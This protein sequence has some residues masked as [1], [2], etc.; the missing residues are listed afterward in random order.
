MKYLLGI[1]LAAASFSSSATV[2]SI[3]SQCERDYPKF[4]EMVNCLSTNIMRDNNL[5]DDQEAR[6]YVATA[7]NLAGKVQRKQIYEDDAVLQLQEKYN[8]MNAAYQAGLAP[9]VKQ[10]GFT[11]FIKK[12]LQDGPS[13][14]IIIRQDRGSE[15]CSSPNG[16]INYLCETQKGINH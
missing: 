9:P 15:N 16:P 10:D 3:Q 6:T 2:Y 5:R 12:R 1:I 8:R 4:T 13:Q 14:R 7:K 11:S